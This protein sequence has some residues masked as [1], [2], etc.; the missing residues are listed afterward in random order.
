MDPITSAT[1]L[2]GLHLASQVGNT[3]ANKVDTA[4]Q[5]SKLFQNQSL[6]NVTQVARVEPIAVLDTDCINVDFI[7]DVVQTMQTLFTGY[8]LQAINLLTTVNGVSAASK[9]ANLNPDRGSFDWTAFRNG[10]Y[11]SESYTHKLPSKK[12]VKS[13]SLESDKPIGG[14]AAAQVSQDAT[15]LVTGKSYSVSVGEGANKATIQIG[16]RLLIT[17]LASTP[18]SNMLTFKTAADMDMGERYHSWRAGR[19][20]FVRDLI[21]CRDLITKHRNMAASDKSSVYRNILNRETNNLKMGL[22][23]GVPSLATSSNLVIIST[24]TLSKVEQQLGGKISMPQIKEVL[25]K[26]TNIMILAVV[27]KSWE[28]IT[29]Y[30]DGIALPTQ[31]SAKDLKTSNKGNGP[32]VADIMKAFIGGSNINL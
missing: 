13:I 32:D 4:V 28:R 6:I 19:I 15:N 2:G 7:G 31:A 18:L 27:D 12:D 23:T 24:D 3:L 5:S 21:L 14:K 9:I 30:H 1:V 17:T 8:Y 16:I 20:D 26:N 22:L 10:T 25:F 11:A 29:F